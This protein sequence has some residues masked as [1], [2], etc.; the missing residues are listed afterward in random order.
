VI[1]RVVLIACLAVGLSGCGGSTSSKLHGT[2]AVGSGGSEGVSLISTASGVTQKV[3]TAYRVVDADL[4]PDGRRVAVAGLKGIWIMDRNGSDARLILDESNL[5]FGAGALAW[6]PDGRRL[7]FIRDDSLYTI[8][9]HGGSVTLV[10]DH[11]DA[12]AWSPDGTEIIFVHNPEL[13]SRNG[14]ISAIGTDGRGLHRVVAFGKWFGPN[15][16]PDGSKIAFYRNGMRGV[17]VVSANGG[18]TRRIVRNGFQ[19][20]WSPD[21]RY[22]AFLRDVDCGEAVCSSRTFV[23]PAS[24]GRAHA[25]GP[26]IADMVLLSWSR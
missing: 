13:S 8:S 18:K 1:R 11:A 7:A 9:T 20:T 21:S 15:V 17:Y 3:A 10:T 4:S 23:I 14:A 5:E 16:S 12:P 19:P 25:Y 24:G 22:L 2:I 26:V 6:S